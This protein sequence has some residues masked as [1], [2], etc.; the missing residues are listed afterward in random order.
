MMIKKV[1]IAEDHETA[2]LSVQRTLE[3]LGL[4]LL[5]HVF[6]CD[7]A[8]LKLQKGV[9]DGDPYDLLIT[10]L[11]F[12]EDHSKQKLPDGTALIKA[13][14]A[15]QPDLKILVFSAEGRPA[16]IDSLFGKYG[17]DGY[18]RKA[19]N[20]ARELKTAIGLI[21]KEQRHFPR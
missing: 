7:D 17:I 8:L 21:D 3:E 18:V 11:S 9:Q 4:T 6:Y 5:H 1:L 19:R 10:D 15:V 12:E 20:D 2:N 16:V 14:R 13:A